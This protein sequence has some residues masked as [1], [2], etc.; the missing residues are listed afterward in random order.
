M[1]RKRLCDPKN[2]P[3]KERK[4]SYSS[5]SIKPGPNRA[6]GTTQQRA[7]R[8]QEERKGQEIIQH[9]ESRCVAPHGQCAG[10]P[11]PPHP[12]PSAESGPWGSVLS[13]T[14]PPRHR[15]RSPSSVTLVAQAQRRHGASPTRARHPTQPQPHASTPSFTR[16][17]RPRATLHTLKCT[18]MVSNTRTNGCGVSERRGT[19]SPAT[20]SRQKHDCE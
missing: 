6:S 16:A 14:L 4:V 19:C 20:A 12:N 9:R 2:S 17:Q 5:H 10:G 11:R 15:E 7:A 8:N 3:R 13:P 18:V 1:G